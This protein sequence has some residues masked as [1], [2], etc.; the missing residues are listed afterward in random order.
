MR[1]GK[2]GS[3]DLQSFHIDPFYFPNPS[4]AQR[5]ATVKL[6]LEMEIGITGGEEVGVSRNAYCDLEQFNRI[7]S[8]NAYCDLELFH[9]IVLHHT[10]V[11]MACSFEEF[12]WPCVLM[13]RYNPFKRLFDVL[14]RVV[15]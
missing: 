13:G 9:R 8:L 1:E 12:S 3:N 15:F 10:V 4:N 7:V 6:W 5:M 2:R 11:G 14:L